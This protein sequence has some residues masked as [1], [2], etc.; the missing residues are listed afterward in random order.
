MNLTEFDI[1]EKLFIRS[2][3][4]AKRYYPTDG[5][6][7]IKMTGLSEPQFIK[8]LS[9]IVVDHGILSNQISSVEQIVSIL[10]AQNGMQNKFKTLVNRL[11]HLLD[12]CN[13]HS[14]QMLIDAEQT[15]LQP[16]IDLLALM[17]MKKYH[18]NQVTVF[19]TYQCYL[20]VNKLIMIR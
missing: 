15:Y 13:S 8:E 9:K 18:Q 10:S 20:K 17:M 5:I 6:V 4:S 16:A 7:A 3:N 19:N 1:N 2:I 12:H 11:Q 14:I